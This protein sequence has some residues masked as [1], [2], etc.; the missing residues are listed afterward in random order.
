VQD[1][2]PVENNLGARINVIVGLGVLSVENLTID[3][4]TKKI[5]FGT[6]DSLPFAVAIP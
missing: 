6:V 5:I 2:S 1:L 3:Y 4:E